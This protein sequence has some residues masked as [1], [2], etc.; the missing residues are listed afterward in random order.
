V[1]PSPADTG[2]L[3]PVPPASGSPASSPPSSGSPF[4]LT[5]SLSPSAFSPPVTPAPD[6]TELRSP[7]APSTPTYGPVTPSY[8]PDPPVSGPLSPGPL[9]PGSLNS[10]PAFGDPPVSRPSAFTSAPPPAPAG[11]GSPA[12]GRRRA[13]PLS[14]RPDPDAPPGWSAVVAADRVYFDTVIAVGAPDASAIRFPDYCSERRFPLTGTQMRI[15]RHSASRGFAPE[16]DL[17]GPPTDPGI[18]RLHAVLIPEPDGTWAILDP[19]SE[20]GTRVNNIEIATDQRVP[21]RNG[22]RIHL[23]AWTLVTIYAG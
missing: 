18:S 8:P 7:A 3:P 10:S 9:S 4:S 23:G 16:I 12:P 20:N 15:G 5:P 1:T 14:G 19:G 6:Q 17:T 21:L 22:D 13:D 11:S 2:P